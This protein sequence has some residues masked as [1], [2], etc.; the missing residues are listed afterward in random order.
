M[1][2]W[3]PLLQHVPS[4]PPLPPGHA[5]GG[6]TDVSRRVLA[7]AGDMGGLTSVDVLTQSPGNVTGSRYLKQTV[8]TSCQ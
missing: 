6:R 5:G 8:V 3:C 7:C 4:R 1:N 2:E